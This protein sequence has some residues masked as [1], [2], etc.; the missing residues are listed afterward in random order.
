MNIFNH[1]ILV[2]IPMLLACILNKI[3]RFTMRTPVMKYFYSSKAIRALLCFFC[4][5]LIFVEK[6]T[7]KQKSDRLR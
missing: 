5:F 7:R 2:I 3:L 1:V 4:F 6:N